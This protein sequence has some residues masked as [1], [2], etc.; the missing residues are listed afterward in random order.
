MK[1]VLLLEQFP[2]VAIVMKELIS[3][4]YPDSKVVTKLNLNEASI[5]IAEYDAV[6]CDL[7]GDAEEQQQQITK[8][9]EQFRFAKRIFVSGM[10]TDVLQE[11]AQERDCLLID[12]TAPY[13][14]LMEAVHKFDHSKKSSINL[15]DIRNEFHSKIQLPG[16]EKPLTIKQARVM[17]LCAQG[18]TGKEIAR[19]MNLSPETIRAHIRQSYARLHAKNRAHAVTNYTL[20]KELAQRVHGLEEEATV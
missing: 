16:A 3:N 15:T 4:V 9:T 7:Y 13:K 2:L 8:I 12:R 6:F 5:D 18:Y 20:A 11:H 17:E 19:A 14:D 1:N 10:V